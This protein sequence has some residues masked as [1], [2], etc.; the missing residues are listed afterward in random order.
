MPAQV[1][2]SIEVATLVG[3][4][5]DAVY[6]IEDT[7]G[8]GS[9]ANATYPQYMDV[10]KMDRA[11]EYNYRI[12]GFGKHIQR[13]EQQPVSYD[14]YEYGEVQT[15]RPANWALGLRISQEAIED[16]AANPYGDFE[17]V[18]LEAWS[19]ITRRFRRSATWTVEQECADIFTNATSTAAKYVM[20]DGTALASASHTGLKNPV[21]TWSNLPSASSLTQAALYDAITMTTIIP[22]DVGNYIPIEKEF[23][24]MVGT[25]NLFKINEI[26]ATLNQTD[27]ANN[28]VNQVGPKGMIKLK[29]VVNQYLGSTFKGFILIAPTQASCRWKWRVKPEFAKESDFE[30]IAQKFRSRMRGVA[31]VMDPHGIVVNTG[32]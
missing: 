31:T 3:T 21:P 22:D 13:T 7:N 15:V 26:I 12:G 11:Q 23:T 5:L 8:S 32:A 25:W 27:T 17:Q 10:Q 20:R 19:E 6:E 16:L 14:G 24:V 18:K 4:A 1:Q 29:P 28:T 2:S 30:A 9:E